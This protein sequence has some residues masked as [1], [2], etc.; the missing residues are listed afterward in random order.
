MPISYCF[1]CG[2]NFERTDTVQKVCSKSCKSARARHI[3]KL[4]K[5][6]VRKCRTPFKQAFGQRGEAIR[7]AYGRGQGFY[8]CSCGTYH[9]TSLASYDFV[10]Q[11]NEALERYKLS[12]T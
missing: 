2:R 8:P 4:N 6:G 5:A 7:K 1:W 11:A 9:L 10:N 3:S 12:L